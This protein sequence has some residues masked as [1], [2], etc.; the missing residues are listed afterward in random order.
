MKGGG[1]GVAA[2]CGPP[3]AATAFSVTLEFKISVLSPLPLSFYKVYAF[4][5]RQICFVVP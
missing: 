3:A 5:L 1:T 4:E 2:V